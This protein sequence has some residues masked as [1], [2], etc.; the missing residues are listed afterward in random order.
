MSVNCEAERAQIADLA[1][2]LKQATRDAIEEQ[3]KKKLY[4]TQRDELMRERDELMRERDALRRERDQTAEV[5]DHYAELMMAVVDAWGGK[6]R[7][8][9]AMRNWLDNLPYIVQALK[10]P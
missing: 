9:P 7:A 1:S 8:D 5:R 4:K 10:K 2:R 3:T 6:N